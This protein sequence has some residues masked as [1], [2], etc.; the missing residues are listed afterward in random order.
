MGLAFAELIRK[1]PEVDPRI[2][3]DYQDQDYYF[4]I[5]IDDRDLIPIKIDIP[6]MPEEHLIEGFGRPAKEQRWRVPKM[7]KRLKYLQG[8]FETLEEIWEE[9]DVQREAYVKEIA[10]IQEQWE[11]RL[12]GH[13]LYIN[14]KPTYIDGWHYFYCGFWTIDIGLPDFRDR[15]R[16]WFMAVRHVY[17]ETRT[18]ANLDEFGWG[19]PDE[20]EEYELIDTG[21]RVFYGVNYP[22]HRR[23]GA[24]Y[25]A[26][27]INYEMISRTSNAWGGIQ[28]MNDT[29]ARKAFTKFLV[30]P[31]KKLPFFFKPNY[32]GST[33]PKTEMSFDAVATRIS[34]KGALISSGEGLGSL[35]DYGPADKGHYD[36]D[37]LY[38]HHDDEV[39]KLKPPN[40][41]WERHQVVKECLTIG[42]NIIGLT[43]K[44]STV[45]EMEKGGGKIF[46]HQCKMSMYHQRNENGQ[47]R[48]GLVNIFMPAHDGLEGFI[49]KYGYSVI[50]EPTPEQAAHTGRKMGARQYLMNK[51][52]GYRDAGDIEGLSE[53][54]RLYPMTWRECFR[55]KAKQS[56]FN[57]NKIEDR[58]DDLRFAKN[59][60]IRV[61][62]LRWKDSVR[63]GEVEFYDT[64]GGK[65]RISQLLT[66]SGEDSETIRPNQKK[67]DQVEQTWIPL[68]T[69]FGIAGG[70]PFKFNRTEYNRKSDAA[71]SVVRKGRY[72][73]IKGE[74]VKKRRFICTY[75]NRTRDKWEY[76]EDMLM[77]CVYYGVQ[78]F[79]EVN[80]DLLWDYFEQRGYRNY[81]LHR[82]DPTQNKFR[83]TPGASTN[84]KIKQDI[85]TE[86]MTWIENEIEE[87]L[88]IEVLEQCRDIGGPEE[89]TDFDLFTAGGYSL[90]GTLSI[91]DEMQK[92]QGEESDVSRYFRKR[93]YKR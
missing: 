57:L 81:L 29:S 32:E 88:H 83:N 16:R 65:F 44:T 53:E 15:D 47:T 41:C 64:P 27:C 17:N 35:I 66:S 10:W 67:W 60:P 30:A 80:I 52:K 38:Y 21:F 71:G 5:N 39:G 11:R 72:E 28:S 4:H 22:K 69:S 93:K 26:E 43:V 50:D 14:G 40:N 23:E 45:G 24:T 49:D 36:G 84:E 18:F 90:L 76:A 3:K 25:R 58:I 1:Y 55:P 82:W 48:S 77:M 20:R 91:Y 63:D 42:G 46:E 75:S 2:L 9:L 54:I 13:W 8:R 56:G 68:N 89:M 59:L 12:N 92:L 37:K 19:I 78:M 31:W 33:N 7:P 74:L 85:F 79:P 62:N 34:S 6:D 51:R 87:E 86:Y 73:V 61:G 70:D